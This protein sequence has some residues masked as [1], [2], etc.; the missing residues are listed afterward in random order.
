MTARNV[1]VIAFGGAI[2]VSATVLWA[3]AMTAAFSYPLS[4]VLSFLGGVVI[5]N[6]TTLVVMDRVSQ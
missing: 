6:I 1:R 5:G 2:A 4:A 3:L